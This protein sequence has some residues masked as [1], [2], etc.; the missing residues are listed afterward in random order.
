MREAPDTNEQDL[1]G[2]LAGGPP[3]AGNQDPAAWADEVARR[4]GEVS[5]PTPTLGQALSS[6]GVDALYAGAAEAAG[7]LLRAAL[8]HLS[9]DEKP[10]DR[11]RALHNLAIVAETGSELDEAVELNSVALGLFEQ[12]GDGRGQAECL[13]GLG[14][15]GIAGERY[16]EAI[17][18]L[19]RSLDLF[20]SFGDLAAQAAAAYALAI[21]HQN[22]AQFDEAN[23]LFTTSVVIWRE[24]GFGQG[25]TEA[26]QGLG[27]VAQSQ[28]RYGAAAKFHADALPMLHEI[29]EWPG[30]SESLEGVA[31]GLLG[32][33]Q[34]GESTELFGAAT[35]LRDR[36]GEAVPQ[37]VLDRVAADI[38]TLRIRLG[39]AEFE[40]HWADGHARPTSSAIAL[41]VELA[42][43]AS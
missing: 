22:L 29:Q 3:E 21:A 2:L 12:A 34:D 35:G 39:P 42:K 15:C 36:L 6:A 16:A 18:Q 10:D 20:E 19:R 8:P 23:R 33:E 5:T 38:A 28:G 40:R 24:L 41:A 7:V 26:L 43:R 37:A 14:T 11:A 25:L 1:F 27:E 30:V 4:A 17:I 32:L 31:L 9:D 13:H